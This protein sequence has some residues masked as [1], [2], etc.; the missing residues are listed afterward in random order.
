[1]GEGEASAL[2]IRVCFPEEVTF[3]ACRTLE[4]VKAAR[5]NKFLFASVTTVEL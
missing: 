2:G 4:T 5:I 1:M 3:R